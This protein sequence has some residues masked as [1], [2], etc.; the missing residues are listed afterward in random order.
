MR[1]THCFAEKDPIEDG[2]WDFVGNTSQKSK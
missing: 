2:N 1:D